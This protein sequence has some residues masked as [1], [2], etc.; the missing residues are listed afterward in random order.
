[1]LKTTADSRAVLGR[2]GGE[3]FAVFIPGANLAVAR[4][5]AEGVRSG[6]A[7]LSLANRRASASFGVAQLRPD[8]SLPDLM[9]RADIAL[10]QAKAAGRD[11]VCTAD[12][13]AV[14][15]LAGLSA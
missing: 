8:D 15:P 6:F 12:P 7:G 5:Y 14:L 10:Y 4:L 3:E 13:G 2:L 11:R 9:R 1:V